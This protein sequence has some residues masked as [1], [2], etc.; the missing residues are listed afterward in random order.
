MD[1]RAKQKAAVLRLLALD[2]EEADAATVDW[3][4][5]ILDAPCRELLAPLLSVNELR[6]RGVTLH[7]PLEG[8]R[9]ALDDVAAVYLCRPTEANAARIARD[10]AR[11][12]R[13]AGWKP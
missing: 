7:A 6:T 1:V 13:C 12:L 10:A 8:E 5:L 2:D 11:G 3:R 4:V 9:D